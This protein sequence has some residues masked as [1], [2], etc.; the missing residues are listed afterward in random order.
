MNCEAYRE[1]MDLVLKPGGNSPIYNCMLSIHD[2]RNN[3]FFSEARGSFGD[4]ENRATPECLFRTGSITKPFTA[5]I[6]LQLVEEGK[7]KTEDLYFDLLDKETKNRLSGLHFHNNIDFSGDISVLHLLQHRSGLCDYFADDERFLAYV[8]KHPF[9]SWNWRLVLEKYFEMELNN[10]PAFKPGNG[11]HYSDTN[12][13]L[14]AVL[15]EQL[16]KKPLHKVLDE[17]IITPLGL[18]DT[19]LEFYQSPG[20][21]APLV[22]PHYR[23]YSLKEVNTSF[24]WGG[25]GLVSTLRDLDIF[26]RALLKGEL[27]KKEET[28][29]LM[30]QFNDIVAETKSGSAGYGSGIQKKEIHSHT[31]IGHNSSYGSMMYYDPQQDISIV[32]SLNQAAALHKAEWLINKVIKELYE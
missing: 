5:A 19:Y 30:M 6:I 29:S 3:I 4:S 13:L 21:A 25:G 32:L 7:L 11:F 12:Y 16:T 22:F 18:K 14:L 8:M 31:F 28:L 24:D 20:T 10:K 9:K 27:F 15:I 23:Q 26:I 17:R 1:M 2:G